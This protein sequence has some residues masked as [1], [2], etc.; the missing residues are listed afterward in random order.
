M[1]LIPKFLRRRKR[2]PDSDGDD[3]L[4]DQPAAASDG[5]GADESIEVRG[6][7][8][9]DPAAERIEV[10][11]I[12]EKDP[13]SERIEVR[14]DVPDDGQGEAAADGGA[15]P[16]A[17]AEGRRQALIREAMINRARAKRVFD[18]LSPETRDRIF[19]AVLG[20]DWKQRYSDDG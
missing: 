18:E 19:S 15:T 10:R 14:D 8:E 9:K 2:E 16:G 13:E 20:P 1:R 7:P 17:S 12:P 3:P 11:G 4:I 5:E 6:I